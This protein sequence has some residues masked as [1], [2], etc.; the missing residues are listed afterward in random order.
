[1]PAHADLFCQWPALE[2]IDSVTLQFSAASVEHALR[3]MNCLSA[4]ASALR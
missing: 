2:R 4:M 3:M 1:T